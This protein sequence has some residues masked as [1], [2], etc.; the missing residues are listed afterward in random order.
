[1]TRRRPVLIGI[2][3]GK[4][5]GVATY[6]K[7]R[8]AAL[9]LAA[10]DVLPYLRGWVEGQTSRGEQVDIGLERFT[11]GTAPG[12]HVSTQGD[13]E[14]VID[15]VVHEFA[16]EPLVQVQLQSAADVKKTVTNRHL[17]KMG[18]YVGAS[19]PH[20]NDA[21]R[22]LGFRML[23]RHPEEYTRVLAGEMI[24]YNRIAEEH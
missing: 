18:W 24:E 4:T 10:E 1:V 13:A 17:R 16:A 7:G 14:V 2:D 23:V 12:H 15:G 9:Q 5:T 20:A 3:P 19:A 22:H 21:G 11:E 6:D 8:F